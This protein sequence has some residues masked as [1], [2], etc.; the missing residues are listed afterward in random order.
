MR[1]IHPS[2]VVTPDEVRAARLKTLHGLLDRH[3]SAD[4]TMEEAKVL[5]INP[6]LSEVRTAEE[7]GIASS[8]AN[9]EKPVDLKPR[10]GGN[11]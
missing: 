4:L 9:I 1:Q 3:C 10:T 8:A 5:R 7:N 11:Q 2:Q 6:L